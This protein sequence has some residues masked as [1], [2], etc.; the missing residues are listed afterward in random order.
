MIYK[1]SDKFSLRYVAFSLH[2]VFR[3]SLYLDTLIGSLPK[4]ADAT[5]QRTT[6]ECRGTFLQR[7]QLS[8]AKGAQA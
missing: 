1:L 2:S 3:Q 8:G 5:G 7:Y 4:R 6:E